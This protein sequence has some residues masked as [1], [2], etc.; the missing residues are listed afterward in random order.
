MKITC[1]QIEVRVG[2]PDANMRHAEEQIRA[3]AAAEKPDLFVLPEAWNTGYAPG[4]L[5]RSK[6]DRDGANT[7]ALFGALSRELNVNI[8]AGSVTNLRG[9]Q[10]FNTALVFD[11]AG[12]C[13]AEYD[14]IHLFTPMHEDRWY[15]GGESVVT[16]TLDGV[17]C[18]LMICYDLRFPELARSLALAG[19]DLL[20]VP[21]AWPEE[22]IFQHDTLCA[23]RA[24]ENQV[25]LAGCNACGATRGAVFGGH[26][27]LYDP[28]GGAVARADDRE[29]ALTAEADLGKLRK[30]RSAI[31]AL[32]DRRPKLYTNG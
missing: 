20:I 18:G 21:S 30:L 8:A 26:S 12:N 27:A 25:Y 5:T 24:I 13:V 3:A 22:R 7:K 16:C 31:P 14:K 28:L 11:R 4:E 2:D 1:L 23:A 19:A 32:Q 29:C 17:R 6:A 10:L 9:E 15:T